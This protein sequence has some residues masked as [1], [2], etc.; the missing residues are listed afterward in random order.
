MIEQ[1]KTRLAAIPSS[2]LKSIES[3]ASV[4]LVRESPPARERTPIAYVI[5][6]RHSPRSPEFATGV[7]SQQFQTRYGVVIAAPAQAQRTGEQ[8][9]TEIEPIIIKVR[10]QLFGWMPD[11]TADETFMRPMELAGGQLIGLG[12][13]LVMWLEEFAI[14]QSIRSA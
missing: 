7:T 4:A 14:E 10:K 9:A 3:A 1:L 6:L 5:P 13:G 8:A 11:D 2:P 12:A